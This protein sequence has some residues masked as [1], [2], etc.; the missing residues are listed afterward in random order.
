M[1]PLLRT[2]LR[3]RSTR[4]LDV[5]AGRRQDSPTENE[6][7]HRTAPDAARSSASPAHSPCETSARPRPPRCRGRPSIGLHEAVRA[8]PRPT[9]ARSS[10]ARIPGCVVANP[11]DS[12]PFGVWIPRASAAYAPRH[13]L[14]LPA[15]HPASRLRRT[16]RRHQRFRGRDG[17][18]LPI[19]KGCGRIRRPLHDALR[20]SYS[21][22]WITLYKA[23]AKSLCTGDGGSWASDE[24]TCPGN[25]PGAWPNTIFVA[26]GCIATPGA[27]KD[28]CDTSGGLWTDDDATAIGSYCVCGVGRYDDASGS[29]ASI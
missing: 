25:T 28:G 3:D 8:W 5:A 15:S 12:Q 9:W 19:G 10:P 20:K 22:R 11:S 1:R 14:R 18:D 26:G 13:A 6:S 27:S 2:V 7:R 21:S 4:V 29:C 16:D 23:T 24:C 17:A